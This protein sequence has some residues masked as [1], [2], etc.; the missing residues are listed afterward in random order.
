MAGEALAQAAKVAG[1][2]L[3]NIKNQRGKTIFDGMVP[4]TDEQI[5]WSVARLLE[6]TKMLDRFGRE[7]P[8]LEFDKAD[9]LG[10]RIVSAGGEAN[11]SM[12]HTMQ[13]P[14]EQADGVERIRHPDGSWVYIDL[15]NIKIT[16]EANQVKFNINVV[17]CCKD[18]PNSKVTPYEGLH[19][20]SE[21]DLI[22][23]AQLNA[24]LRQNLAQYFGRQLHILPQD[25]LK[26]IFIESQ[27]PYRTLAERYLVKMLEAAV[28]NQ[29][30]QL[31]GGVSFPARLRNREF[32]LQLSVSLPLQLP[33]PFQPQDMQLQDD[34]LL[35]FAPTSAGNHG[36]SPAPGSTG[37]APEDENRRKESSDGKG[38]S[39][40]AGNSGLQSAPSESDGKGRGAKKKSAPIPLSSLAKFRAVIF[41]LD[42]VAVNSERAHL[43]T[44]NMTLAPL[45]L[46]IDEKTWKRN[47]TGTGSRSIMEDVFTRNGIRE[48]VDEWVAKRAEV[49]QKFVER[50]GLPEISGFKDFNSYLVSQGVAT[51]V[52]SG[53]HNSH[54]A[55]SLQSLGLPK[56]LF[57]GQ[58]NVS[59]PKPA[60]DLFLLAAKRL[61]VKPSQCIVFEDSHVGI[62]AARRAGMPCIALSTTLPKKEIDG[63][64][65]FV[66]PNFRS[67][68]LR[69]LFAKLIRKR[70]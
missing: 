26:A 37:K 61:K 57:V 8:L 48:N 51:A 65:A 47:Y 45:G 3:V 46:K 35:L 40:S 32:R 63:K 14:G 7:V 70:R 34:G 55:A 58:E 10:F 18:M 56:M 5:G 59:R 11:N 50:H 52:A 49:Y 24:L 9:P 21:I 17:M 2:L 16:R 44:F 69:K 41:D 64:A 27:L 42:G 67:M 13:R 38:S 43:Q 39:P 29:P 4:Y 30:E 54:I 20:M 36:S 23:F 1:H 12:H 68:V 15:R 19:E 60:P 62:E 33:P 28:R 6:S 22:T 53:G 25:Y 31:L 66:V